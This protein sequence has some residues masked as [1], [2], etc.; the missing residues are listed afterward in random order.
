MLLDT[1]AYKRCSTSLNAARYGNAS[2][3]TRRCST[4]LDLQ[5]PPTLLDAV[6][7][8]DVLDSADAA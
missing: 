5:M 1:G 7:A 6:D 8:V 3:A 4:L 2:N